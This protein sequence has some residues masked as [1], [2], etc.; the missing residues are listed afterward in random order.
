MSNPSVTERVTQAV[1]QTPAAQHDGWRARL[2]RLDPNIGSLGW[3]SFFAD[4]STEI[5]YPLFPF[6]ITTV[7][8]AP[9]AV[10]GVIEGIAEATASITKY[11]FGQWSD[12]TGR[13]RIFAAFGYGLAGL[14]K[15]IIAAATVW[16]VAL[17]GRFVD[18]LGKG[19]RGAPRDALIAASAKDDERGIAFG[20]HRAMDTMGAVLGPLVAI[21]LIQLDVPLRWVFAIAVVPGLIG[22]LVIVLFV[23]EHR[24]EPHRAAF[25]LSLPKAPAFRWLLLGTLVFSVGNSSDMFILLKAQDAIMPSAQST[26][27]GVTGVILLYVLYNVVYSG[28]SIPLGHVSDRVGQL[29]LVLV[30]F[31]VF[32]LVYLGFATAD[33]WPFMVGLFALYGVY[34][35]ATEGTSKALVSRAIPPK[36]HGSALGLYY[37][38]SGLAS[39]AASSIGG[40]LWS[41]VAPWATFVYGAACALLAA[42]VLGVARLRLGRDA[43]LNAAPRTSPENH[44]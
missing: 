42:I 9:A 7:L 24:Q 25:R 2:R 30:G 31:L 22:V 40:V 18:R 41:A 5:V 12:Y 6:F 19:M 17:V 35:A 21:L 37:T 44:A 36:E 34:I 11:P 23:H 10:L 15:L 1:P 16:P 43:G 33:S 14:G 3:V 32:A 26:A 13:R 29:P 27:A 39:F 28:F 20:L 4:L 8:G 38:A